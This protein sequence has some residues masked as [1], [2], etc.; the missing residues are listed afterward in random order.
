[1]V[2][3]RIFLTQFRVQ[4]HVKTKLHDKQV[5]ETVSLKPLS[6]KMVRH[7]KPLFFIVR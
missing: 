6:L 4:D 5:T 7:K 2:C 1:M 3:I